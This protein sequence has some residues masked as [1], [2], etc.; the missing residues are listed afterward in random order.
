MLVDCQK[1][2]SVNTRDKQGYFKGPVGN[3]LDSVR[4]KEIQCGSN[5]TIFIILVELPS[6]PVATK[7]KEEITNSWCRKAETECGKDKDYEGQM[8]QHVENH[9]RHTVHFPEVLCLSIRLQLRCQISPIPWRRDRKLQLFQSLGRTDFTW[10]WTMK[11]W[12]KTQVNKCPYQ[13]ITCPG[14]RTP[15]VKEKKSRC[16]K[17][18]GEGT[19]RLTWGS[20]TTLQMLSQDRNRWREEVKIGL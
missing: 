11:H 12:G 10:M 6:D 9:S 17:A 8:C 7:R 4:N 13:Q 16:L 18:P 5:L 3:R 19:G 2:C 1:F 20:V 15:E 14:R